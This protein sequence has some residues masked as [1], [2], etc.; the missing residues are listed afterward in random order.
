MQ[1][2]NAFSQYKVS[3]LDHPLLRMGIPNADGDREA[4][5]AGEDPHCGVWKAILD[6]VVDPTVTD[7]WGMPL[8]NSRSLRGGGET[9]MGVEVRDDSS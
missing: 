9:T 6:A 7:P 5:G 4:P 3:S 1:A 2:V 8:L